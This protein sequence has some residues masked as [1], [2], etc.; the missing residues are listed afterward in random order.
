MATYFEMTG[1]VTCKSKEREI[2][3][4]EDFVRWMEQWDWYNVKIN[5]WQCEYLVYSRENTRKWR[6]A[7]KVG[8]KC[9]TYQEALDMVERT[10]LYGLL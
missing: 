1:F 5:N 8:I 10:E 3:K 9:I 6:Y 2:S 4:K 7:Q